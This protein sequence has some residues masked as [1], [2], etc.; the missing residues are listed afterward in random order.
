L[1]SFAVKVG[2]RKNCEAMDKRDCATDGI[3]SYVSSMGIDQSRQ[4]KV[5]QGS[6]GHAGD[7]ATWLQAG[8][9]ECATL[10][11]PL[12]DPL[13]LVLL[14]APGVGKGTQAGLLHKW[15]G[16]CHLS[17]GDIFRAA[18]TLPP[19]E[20]TPAIES[21]L[22][23]MKR[24]ELVPDATVLTLVSERHSCLRCSGGF[25][26]DGF[27]RTVTQAEGLKQLLKAENLPLTAVIDYELSIDKIVE[28][29]AGRR[30]CA[31]CKRVFHVTDKLSSPQKCP[32]C[33]GKLYQREDDRPQ[34]IRVRMKAYHLS[35]EPLIKFYRQRNLLQTVSADGTPE[36]I[37]QRT[38][39]ALALPRA[40]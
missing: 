37:F 28:R 16:A 32:V 31:N 8:T 30:V 29:L 19:S 21:A 4:S 18:E 34:A 22:G 25:L 35:T 3:M 14:G 9:S 17:T 12:K 26:L 38:V 33:G 7:R 1:H 10:P 2:A 6:N 40:K 39:D 23:F 20:L 11:S 27:P 36:E 5:M 15:S 24:G 13:R